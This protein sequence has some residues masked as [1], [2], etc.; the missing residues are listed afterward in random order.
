M[1]EDRSDLD[2]KPS[3]LSPRSQSSTGP[4]TQGRDVYGGESLNVKAFRRQLVVAS[5]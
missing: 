2:R 4:D 5:C 3:L 1:D